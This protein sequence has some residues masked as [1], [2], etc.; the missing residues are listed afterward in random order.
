MLVLLVLL[1]GC[2]WADNGGKADVY[3][4][5]YRAINADVDPPE[6]QASQPK[7]SK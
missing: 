6:E 3:I 4:N 7:R 5:T 2:A 1:G